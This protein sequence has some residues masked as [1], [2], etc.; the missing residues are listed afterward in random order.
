MSIDL[1]PIRHNWYRH[2]DKGQ[3]FRVIG[4]DEKAGTVDIQYFDGTTEEL[5]PEAWVELDIEAIEAPENWAGA[6]DIAEADD[7]GTGISDTAPEDWRAPQEEW[8]Q[9]GERDSLIGEEEVDDWEEGRMQEE[10]WEGEA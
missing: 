5:E 3:E 7:F 10:P 8:R 1:D 2:L 9:P 4:V 6:L